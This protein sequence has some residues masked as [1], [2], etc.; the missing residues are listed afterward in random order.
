MVMTF[1][2]TELQILLGFVGQNKSGRKN[3]LQARALELV[4]RKSSP[5]A[6]KIKELYRTVQ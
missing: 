1:R 2:V 6:M 4:R 5:I 3:E